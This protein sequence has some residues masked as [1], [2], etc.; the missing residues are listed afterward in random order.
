MLVPGLCK[1]VSVPWREPTLPRQPQGSRT[2]NLPAVRQRSIHSLSIS[3]SWLPLELYHTRR[4]LPAKMMELQNLET[5]LLTPRAK[6]NHPFCFR[7]IK[8]FG[9]S[10]QRI[11][12]MQWASVPKIPDKA[13]RRRL[14]KALTP[15]PG[16]RAYRRSDRGEFTDL[17]EPLIARLDVHVVDISGLIWRFPMGTILLEELLP[18]LFLSCWTVTLHLHSKIKLLTILIRELMLWLWHH[19]DLCRISPENNKESPFDFQLKKKSLAF[20]NTL[21]FTYHT[22][23]FNQSVQM[24]SMFFKKYVL[25]F[26]FPRMTMMMMWSYFTTSKRKPRLSLCSLVRPPTRTPSHFRSV[27]KTRC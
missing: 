14:G 2:H 15:P 22:L 16:L 11:H 27:S 25:V 13:A 19:N 9:A 10:Q 26:L 7:Q 23:T 21:L 20:Q 5:T 3:R 1:E 24:F 8:Q 6:Q 12:S 18:L 4:L 17:A